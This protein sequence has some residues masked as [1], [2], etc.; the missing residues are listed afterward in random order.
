MDLGEEQPLSREA[1]AS[2]WKLDAR[3]VVPGQSLCDGECEEPQPV[4]VQNFEGP[5]G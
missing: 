2:K 5:D 3:G 1:S 4:L